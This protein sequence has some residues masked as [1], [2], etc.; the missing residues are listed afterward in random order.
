MIRL[1]GAKRLLFKPKQFTTIVMMLIVWAGVTGAL[2]AGISTD[3]RN[4]EYLKGRAQTIAN[5]LSTTDIK[6]LRGNKDDLTSL[7]YNQLKDRLQQIRA[8][9]RDLRSVYLLDQKNGK[10]RFLVD[11]EVPSSVGYSPPGMEYDE[12]SPRLKSAFQASEPLI[13]GPSQDRWDTRIS[14]LTPVFDPSNHKVIAVVGVDTPALTYYAQIAL[15]ALVPLL[16]AAIPFAGLLR[17]MK[18]MNKE[19]E[20]LQLKNQFVSIASHEL[21]SPLAGMLW[22]IQSLTKS[23]S[24]KLTMQQLSMLSDMYRSTE[25]SL[26]TV[27][28]ILDMSIFDRGESHKLQHEQLD[29][30]QVIKQVAATLKL[31]AEEKQIDF[32]RQGDWPNHVYV[33]GDVAALKRAL[34]NVVSNAIK[35]SRENTSIELSYRKADKEHHIGI[36]DHGIGIPAEEQ[37]QVMQGY[38]RA[39][40]ATAVQ[41]HGTG[42]GLWVTQKIIEQHGGRLWLNSKIDDGTTIYI[43]L[44]IANEPKT[45]R[46]PAPQKSAGSGSQDQAPASTGIPSPQIAKL[47]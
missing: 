4:R 22:A 24:S 33:S 29:M 12:A 10:V 9:N 34:M 23:A 27:N 30:V 31:G 13:D 19:H 44:P 15:Y 7:S 37:A 18:L 5:A 40:N 20:I 2:F 16:L 21:R 42:L 11:S 26:A 41:A 14:A 36:R 46:N 1:A 25:S 28:E 43:A 38:Y 39:T 35:Y 45:A 8:G 47:G 3:L 32:V 17:D 6:N